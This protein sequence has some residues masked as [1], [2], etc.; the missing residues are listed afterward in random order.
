MVD[1]DWKILYGNRKAVESFPN[2]KLANDY[3]SCFP[4]VFPASV[5]QQ[6]RSA[7]SDRLELRF[8]GYSS[9]YEQWYK[10]HAF[11]TEDGLSIFFSNIT[12]DKKIRDQL[13][14]E[15]VLREKRIEA[16]SHMAGG[17]AHE[18]SNPL[19]IIHGTANDLR[20][21]ATGEVPFAGVDVL[22]A[23]DRIV[24]TADRAMK[25]LRGL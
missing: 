4:G 25:I 19:A 16:L 8:E 21:L 13:E 23:C 9:Q 1:H 10:I 20:S 17:L 18:I 6:M 12:E 2:F 5:E 11:P 14:L 24:Q 3:W 22:K 15:Q 7:M